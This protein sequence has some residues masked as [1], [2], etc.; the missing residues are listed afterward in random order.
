M[1]T[2]FYQRIFRDAGS[3]RMQHY[4]DTEDQP[5]HPPHN[6]FMVPK[7]VHDG[8][9]EFVYVV[10][11]EGVHTINDMPYSARKG[12]LLFIGFGQT[13]QI[14][15]EGG[16]YYNILL[17]PEYLGVGMEYATDMM[18][19]LLSFVALSEQTGPCFR[20]SG[21]QIDR[22][23]SLI[24]ML[25]KETEEPREYS[26]T[27]TR[28]LLHLLLIHLLRKIKSPETPTSK[29]RLEEITDY[30][31]EHYTEDLSLSSISERFFY[32]SS[33]FSRM[34][35]KCT[36]EAFTSY[37]NSLRIRRAMELLEDETLSV[38]DIAGMVGFG[39]V[40]TFYSQFKRYTQTTPGA[41]RR[42]KEQQ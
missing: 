10:K 14:E 40:K 24:K 20:F 29:D 22:V 4:V 27:A 26:E 15:S 32:N 3:C 23:E 36:G 41:F 18:A 7:H 19:D 30:L 13:H 17:R 2:V 31:K 5:A 16:E 35:K 42:A 38:D 8:F 34:F 21:N 12:T 11:G 6:G 28:N 1:L 37:V 33:Y 9:L 39:D 25:Y